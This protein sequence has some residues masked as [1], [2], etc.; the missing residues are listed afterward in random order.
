MC[1]DCIMGYRYQ[2][3]SWDTDESFIEYAKNLCY[4]TPGCGMF[5]VESG[6][7]RSEALLCSSSSPLIPENSIKTNYTTYI[8][9]K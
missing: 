5:Y 2:K 8:M 6:Q 7:I 4:K 1:G 9:G 3:Q